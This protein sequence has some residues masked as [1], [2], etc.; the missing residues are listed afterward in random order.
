MKATRRAKI[1][2]LGRYVPPKVVTNYDLA[3]RIDTNHDWVVER[4]GIVERHWVEPGTPTSELAAQ[5]VGDLL[6]NRGIEAS[7]VELIV[8]ATVT[9]DMF[10]PAT[11]CI[12]QNKVRATNAWGFDLSAA[13]SGFLYALT[14]G[15]KFIESGAHDKVVVVGSDVMTSIT[16]LEDRSTCVLFGDAAG[17]VLLEPSDEE[18]FGIL[19]YMHEVDGSGGEFL[20]MPAGGSLNPAS[21]ETVDKKMHYVHQEGQP[22]FKY[23]VRKMGEISRGILEKNGYEGK[24]LDLFIAHQANLRIVN[25]AADRLGLEENKVVKNIHKFGNTTAATIPLAIGDALD[26]GRLKKGKLVVFAA[27]GAGYTA[28][29]MLMRWAY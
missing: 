9:P 4:T 18:E 20:Y 24:D 13:C 17:A 16:N 8:V 11:A 10:F 25:A 2:A 27:V 6:K 26:D 1:T 21:H 29:S 15:A 12:V 5:A 19:D 14:V 28:G 3:S 23:A 22:V 7:E